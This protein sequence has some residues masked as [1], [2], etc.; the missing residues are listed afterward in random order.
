MKFH[1]VK[2]KDIAKELG[3]SSSAVSKAL[4]DSYEI[5]EETKK[6]VN[7]YAKRINYRPNPIAQSL[8]QGHTKSIG[9]VVSTIDNHFFSQVINGIESIAHGKGYNVIITQTNESYDIEVQS[10]KHLIFRSIDGILISLSTETENIR[11]LNEINDRGLPIVFFDRVSNAPNTHKI[12]VDNFTGAYEGTMQ[13][14]NSGYH[15]IAHI[16][17]SPNISITIERLE[18][19]KKALKDSGILYKEDYVKYCMHG[20]KYP[21]EIHKALT[22]VLSKADRPN[23]I[24]TASDRITTSTF[25]LLREFNVQIPDEIAIL[26]FTNT[27]LASVLDPPLSTIY[28][29]GFEIGKNAV[30]L[31]IKLIES[32]RPVKEYV[33]TVLPT[34]LFAR[35]S[36]KMLK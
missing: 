33:T 18:G 15:R 6:R 25:T 8:K 1:T 31:L 16:T 36:S 17:S 20:G 27:Q 11:H 5:S 22:E 21:D 26:G 24:F 14:I 7:E 19:Y 32:K 10:I 9:I 13:L 23:A 28:Q 35:A 30:E 34:T 4:N 12:V 2:L 29:P 3:L